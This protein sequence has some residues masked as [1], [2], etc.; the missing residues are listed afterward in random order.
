LLPSGALHGATVV[1]QGPPAVFSSSA[2]AGP[3]SLNTN[4]ISYW[5]LEEASGARADSEPTGTA[6]NL[7]DNNTVTSNPGTIGDAAQF[8]SGNQEYLSRADS[9]NLSTGDID[10]TIAGWFYLDSNNADMRMLGKTGSGQMEYYILFNSNTGRFEFH[11]SNNGTADVALSADN[12]PLF[13][14]LSTWYFIVCWHDSVNN[15]INIS[16]DDGTPD[17]ASHT[18]GVFDGTADFRIGGF[19][20][21]YFNGRADEVGFWKKVLSAPERTE[22]YNGGAGKTCC[23]F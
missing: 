11:V 2:V 19:T 16:V 12:G 5:K 8:D 1:I 4:L 6:Q 21:A 13:P 10:F 22:L 7:T 17:S 14:F 18:T 3:S 23:P 9:T 15:T 20:G